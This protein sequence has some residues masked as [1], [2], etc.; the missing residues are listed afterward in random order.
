ML[1]SKLPRELSLK[2]FLMLDG[3]SLHT[4]RQACQDWNEFII[5]QIWGSRQG[6]NAL[7]RKLKNNWN[8]GIPSE[9]QVK[10]SMESK[11]HLLGM[12]EKYVAVKILRESSRRVTRS[13]KGLPASYH[14][15]MVI[16]NMQNKK[17]NLRF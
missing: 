12:S 13:Q 7:E 2:I 15:V 1:L 5:Q 4:A 14:W 9:T 8:H 16:I 10:L 11:P 17:E 3:V 6:R